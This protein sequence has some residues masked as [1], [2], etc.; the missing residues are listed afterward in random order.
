MGILNGVFSMGFVW[1]N[2]GGVGYY[3]QFFKLCVFIYIFIIVITNV[4]SRCSCPSRNRASH[5]C[6]SPLGSF[7]ALFAT[8]WASKLSDRGKSTGETRDGVF[9]WVFT[10]GLC[11]EDFVRVFLRCGFCM[12]FSFWDLNGYFKW[13]FC[14]GIFKW[15]FCMG[16]INGIF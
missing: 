1:G 12:E 3:G 11:N 8:C 7:F 13:G 4:S 10:R 6:P 15:G 5:H 2:S 14:K 16:I 9:K